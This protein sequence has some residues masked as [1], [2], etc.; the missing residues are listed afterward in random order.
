MTA[1]IL[2]SETTDKD[3]STAEA[4]EVAWINLESGAEFTQRYKPSCPILFG[5]MATHNITPDELVD[6]PPSGSFKL[7]D[8]CEFL[9]GHNI[10]FDHE[11]I[12]KPSVKL[13]DTLSLSRIVFNDN[14]SHSQLACLYRIDMPLAKKLAHG[15]HGALADI[16][17][18][19]IV[20]DYL[21]NQI[22][23]YDYALLAELSELAK[24]PA[25]IGFGKHQGLPFNQIPADYK[26]WYMRQAD[27]DPYVIRAMKGE[28]ALT[29]QSAKELVESR[30]K[31]R[32]DIKNV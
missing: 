25:E 4:I 14:D 1:Y 30:N 29:L 32:M 19:N 7:P 31:S 10:S 20:F 8:D 22:G 2:D 24:I 11:I 3:A 23:T 26:A 6:C 15:A 21:C 18:N 5:A 28:V 17:M 16:R 12:G 27:T 9:V 13:I